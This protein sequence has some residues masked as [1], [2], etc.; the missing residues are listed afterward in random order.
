MEVYLS[1]LSGN[2]DRPTD[3]KVDREVPINAAIYIF[4]DG[5]R[6]VNAPET[7][8][9][10]IGQDVVINCRYGSL[11]Y[12]VSISIIRYRITMVL[13]DY[14]RYSTLGT[15]RYKTKHQ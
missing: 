9:G 8:Y 12:T 4:Q 1:V 2:I 3:I 13:N 11:W 15:V 5:L 14:Y 7:Q 10:R 6:W